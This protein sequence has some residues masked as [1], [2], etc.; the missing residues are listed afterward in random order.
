MVKRLCYYSPSDCN[1]LKIAILLYISRLSDIITKR[2]NNTD[3]TSTR[4]SHKQRK[5]VGG[6]SIFYQI[7]LFLL[8]SDFSLIFSTL[9]IFKK[10]RKKVKRFFF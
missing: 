2:Q 3:N 9:T 7:S 1:W 5:Q 4:K 6:A 8:F 10:C